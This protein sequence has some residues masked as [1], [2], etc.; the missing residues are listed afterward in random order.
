MKTVLIIVFYKKC[1]IW[2]V[3]WV[4]LYESL[5]SQWN[6]NVTKVIANFSHISKIMSPNSYISPQKCK[7][8]TA[9]FH[10]GI[11]R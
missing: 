7:L 9:S 4:T 11:K 8:T 2:A 6:K 1:F 10:D 5:F 3:V